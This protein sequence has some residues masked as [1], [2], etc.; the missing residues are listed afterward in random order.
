MLGGLCPWGPTGPSPKEQRGTILMW[1]EPPAGGAVRVWCTVDR[2]TKPQIQDQQ[3]GY[4]QTHKDAVLK[5][6]IFFP[7]LYTHFYMSGCTGGPEVIQSFIRRLGDLLLWFI[8]LIF[9]WVAGKLNIKHQNKDSYIGFK[10][11]LFIIF[12]GYETE[13]KRNFRIL[14]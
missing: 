2:V 10:K 7:E 5:I 14:Y 11:S 12:N 9:C 8:G 6:K 3:C 13:R 1:K 4:C